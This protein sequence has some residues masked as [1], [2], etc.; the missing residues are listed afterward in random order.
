MQ[1]A[2]QASAFLGI[3]SRQVYELAAKGLLPCYR[4]GSAVRFE[5]ADLDVYK[6]SCRSASTPVTS[7]GATFSTG[8]SGTS[9]SALLAYFREAGVAPKR[10][11]STASKRPGSMHLRPV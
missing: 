1:N 6:Q 10:K 9:E 8:K 2:R 11:S 4:F 7:A 5:Q 3:S